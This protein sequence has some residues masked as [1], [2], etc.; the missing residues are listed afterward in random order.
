MDVFRGRFDFDNFTTQIHDLNPGIDPF[1]GGLFWVFRT[2]EGNVDVDLLDA[3]ASMRLD[4]LRLADHFTIPNS[5][6]GDPKA[7]VPATLDLHVRWQGK[8]AAVDERDPSNS[9]VGRY[10]HSLATMRWSAT[11]GTFRFE[12]HAG[13]SDDPTM[14]GFAQI[15]RQRNGIFFSGQQHLEDD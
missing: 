7:A 13:R 5:L 1:P 2:D 3:S 6:D 15:G 9:R 11:V 8:E 10:I 14:T 12:A 4:G